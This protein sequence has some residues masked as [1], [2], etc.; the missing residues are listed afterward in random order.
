MPVWLTIKAILT[1]FKVTIVELDFR[2][3]NDCVDLGEL[4]LNKVLLMKDA[5]YPW[6][7]LVPKRDGVSEL[8][9]LTNEDQ[10]QFIWESTFVSSSLMEIFGGD[11]MNVAALGNVVSQ[12]H[13]HHVVRFKTDPAWP[14]PVWGTVPA[15]AYNRKSLQNRV[16]KIQQALSKSQFKPNVDWRTEQQ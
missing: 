5:N 4:L 2:L 8:Y 15:V 1:V 7:I 6:V 9:S 3:Q 10:E 11:K 12:L 16:E 13:I 14:N